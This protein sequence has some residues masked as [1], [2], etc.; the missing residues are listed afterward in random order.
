MLRWLS[1]I[2]VVVVALTVTGCGTKAKELPPVNEASQAAPDPK[3]AMNKAMQGMPPDV[4][5]KME[6]NMPK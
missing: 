6:Q 2:G 4:R 5:K 1:F 3:E